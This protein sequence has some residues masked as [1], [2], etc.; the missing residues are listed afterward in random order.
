LETAKVVARSKKITLPRRVAKP[1][2]RTPR[3]DPDPVGFCTEP[4]EIIA[5]L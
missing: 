3:D 1:T 5:E 2:S 4:A